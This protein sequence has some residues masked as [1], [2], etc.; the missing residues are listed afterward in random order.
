MK[1]LWWLLAGLLLGLLLGQS[2]PTTAQ[3]PMRIFGT[4]TTTGSA[5]PIGAIGDALKVVGQ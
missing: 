1:R 5:V 4:N 3:A 2:L